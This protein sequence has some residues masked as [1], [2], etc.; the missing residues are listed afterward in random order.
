MRGY[1]V[2]VKTLSDQ[3]ECRYLGC[4]VEGY[5]H[6]DMLVEWMGRTPR[7]TING[8]TRCI[9]DNS[10]ADFEANRRVGCALKGGGG[11]GG[12]ES[13][14]ATATTAAITSNNLSYPLQSSPGEGTPPMSGS[15]YGWITT[16]SYMR[17]STMRHSMLI[18]SISYHQ[19]C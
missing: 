7:Y 18:L 16:N 11:G 4:R 10:H 13:A 19:N 2:G 9:Y 5:T 15:G 14:T 8:C 1:L 12:R 17:H 3:S 6:G